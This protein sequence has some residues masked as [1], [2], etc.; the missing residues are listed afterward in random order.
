MKGSIYIFRIWTIE[1]SEVD[2]PVIDQ[3]PKN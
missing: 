3:I 2:Y 1:D